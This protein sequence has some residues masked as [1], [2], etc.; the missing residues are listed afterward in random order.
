MMANCSRVTAP[1]PMLGPMTYYL[2]IPKDAPESVLS[3]LGPEERQIVSFEMALARG[4]T[5]GVRGF[6]DVF[7]KSSPYFLTIAGAAIG[8]AVMQGDKD[9]FSR[10]YAD[11]LRFGDIYNHP[12]AK[13]GAYS[14]I[15]YRNLVVMHNHFTGNH[16]ATNLT[17][18]EFFLARHLKMGKSYKALAQ[19]LDVSPGRLHNIV[20]QLYGKLN[21][22][23]R[24]ELDPFVW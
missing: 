11:I 22:H 10:I 1:L 2:Q 18:R 5:D 16:R 17:V 3:T 24:E 7:F 20:I 13:L 14:E 4:Q 9:L 19:Y 6:Y 8:G 23:S 12:C 15:H 21:V